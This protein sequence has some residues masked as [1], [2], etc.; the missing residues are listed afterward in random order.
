MMGITAFLT[1]ASG[2]GTVYVTLAAEHFG[3]VMAP[4]IPCNR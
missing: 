1:L 2:S 4:L 3:E